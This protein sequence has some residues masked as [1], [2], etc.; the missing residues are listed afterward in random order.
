[1]RLAGVSIA[2]SGPGNPFELVGFGF[3]RSP[4]CWRHVLPCAVWRPSWVKQGSKSSRQAPPVPAP[5][6]A[7]NPV[8]QTP[9]RSPGPRYAEPAS[10]PRVFFSF[11]LWKVQFLDPSCAGGYRRVPARAAA[12]LVVGILRARV[13]CCVLE[14]MEGGGQS[15][16]CVVVSETVPAGWRN[17][18]TTG[19]PLSLRLLSARPPDTPPPPTATPCCM[20][21]HGLS[22]MV[23]WHR[24]VTPEPLWPR[25]QWPVSVARKLAATGEVAP[26]D[27]TRAGDASDDAEECPICLEVRGAREGGGA[28]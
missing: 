23:V 17:K 18:K 13:V 2:S 22:Y 9:V 21:A 5:A 3:C 12:V 20:R 25:S 15:P 24:L 6:P 8:H 26:L 7:P 27:N 10:P 28:G 16:R 19:V 14:G 1:V 11:P 4:P